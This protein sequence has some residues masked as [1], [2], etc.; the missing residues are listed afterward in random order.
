MPANSSKRVLGGH[1]KVKVAIAQ[2][3]PV[4]MDRAASV[5]RACGIIEEAGR[6]GAQLV[7]FPEAW[8]AGYPYWTEGWDSSLPQWAGGRIL[9]RDNALVVPSDDAERIAHAA[10]KAGAYVALGCNEMDARPEVSTIYNSLV[11]FAPDGSVLG[12]HRKLMPTFTERMFWGQGDASDV[13]VFDTDIGRLG[14]LICG[15]HLMTLARAAMIAQGED[16]H[17]AVFPGAFELHTGPQLEEPEKAGCFWG[18]FEVRAHAFE[19][20]AFVLSGCAVLNDAD[21]APDFPYKGRMNIGYAH[22]GSEIVAPLGIALAGPA[23]GETVLYAELEAWMIK[24]T[25]AI[26]DTMGHY[27]RPDVFKL[28]VHR[29]RGWTPAASARDLS[30][31]RLALSDDALR[32]SADQRDVDAEPVL[33]MAEGVRRALG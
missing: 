15:E 14:G 3:S 8:L 32:R 4:F 27:A 6:N 10:R 7:V 17:I 21:V 13:V 2:K 16:I 26:I 12:R 18:H 19:A 11:F 5:A 22:G 9:F 33:E 28:L 1:D 30:V 23:Y 25:K 24:A 29:E 20:G 31:I